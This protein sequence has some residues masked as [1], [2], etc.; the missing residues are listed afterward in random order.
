M[1]ASEPVT[2]T[3]DGA[4]TV[5]TFDAPPLNL[6]D[7]TLSD[8]LARAVQTLE[9]ESTRGVLFR[10]EGRVVSGGV[11]VSMFA[12]LDGPEQAERVFEELIDVAGRVARLPCPTVFAAHALCLTWAPRRR[13]A[14]GWWR[15]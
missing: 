2:L 3:H 9:S 4:L 13:R 6:F 10:A 1:S 8:G 11:D 7:R 14:S 5:V 15:R 12:A